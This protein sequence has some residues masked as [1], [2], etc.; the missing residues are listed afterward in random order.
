MG[1]GPSS[2][3]CYQTAVPSGLVAQWYLVLP[4]DYPT[5]STFDICHGLNEPEL[6]R[7]VSLVEKTTDN[8]V[9]A[10]RQFSIKL[11]KM[12]MEHNRSTNWRPYGAVICMTALMAIEFVMEGI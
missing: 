3:R 2:L 9:P 5:G 6:R 8:G 12:I 7:S 11:F 10:A 4:Y 1:L